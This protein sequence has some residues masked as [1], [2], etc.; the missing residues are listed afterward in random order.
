MFPVYVSSTFK[1]LRSHRRAVA[2]AARLLGCQPIAMEDYVARDDRPLDAC[3]ADVRRAHV[4]I[5]I[6]AWRYGY[7]PAGTTEAS[8]TWST[9]RPASGGSLACSSCTARR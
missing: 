6:V 1:D 2:D 3:I 8:R 4:Y 7:R 5:G 9:R